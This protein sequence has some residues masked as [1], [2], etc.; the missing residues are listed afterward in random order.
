MLKWTEIEQKT[1]V[2]ILAKIKQEL[3]QRDFPVEETSAF[4]ALELRFRQFGLIGN[5]EEKNEI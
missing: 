3:K 5:L 1:S 2:E 4:F